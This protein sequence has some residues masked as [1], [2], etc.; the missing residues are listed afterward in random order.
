MSTYQE[1]L[2]VTEK[3]GYSLGDLAANLIFQ[4]LVTFLAFFYTDVFGIPA[5]TAA[6]IIFVVGL[7]GAFVFTPLVAVLADRTNTR[8]GKFRPWILWTAVPFGVLTLL[9]FS[10]PDLGPQGKVFYAAA[11]YTL[12]VLV[13]AANNLPYAALSGVLTGNMADRNSMSSYRFVAVMIAQFIIQVLL[14]PLVLILGGGDKVQ[15]FHN[16]MLLFAAV[17]TV[18]LLV[19]F[20]TTRERIVPAQEQKSSIAQDLADL[21]RNRPWL[22]VLLVTIL[23]FIALALKGGMYVYYFKYYLDEAALAA[24]LQN[25]GFN[26]FIGGLNSALTGVGLTEFHWPEDAPTSAFSLFSAGG[27]IFMIIGIGFSKK[28]ADRFG[29]RDV[30]G[31]ALVLATLFLLAFYVF[32]PDAIGLVFGSQILHGFF[33]GITVPLLWAMVADVADYSEWKNHRRAT[34]IIFSA[35]LCGLKVGLSVGGAMVAGILAYYAY[36]PGGATQPQQ[37]VDGIRLAVS[38]YTSLPF[39]G[40]AALLFFYEINKPME[41]RIERELGERRALAGAAS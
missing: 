19:T 34:A 15:G 29:K 28:L 23:V 8:W 2:S 20:F 10:T 38:L 6:T 12:L 39:L 27:I 5:G 40:A 16:T 3:V 26:S 21:A 11:T 33:Y 37:A 4:T 32:P 31:V 22:V 1:K 24:F 36:V 35:I 30:Y 17:G 7:V 13:Y 18:F 41:S 25:V 9:A 14:L